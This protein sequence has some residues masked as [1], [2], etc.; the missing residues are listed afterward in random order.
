M[1]KGKLAKWAEN[2]HFDHVFEPSLNEI[3]EGATFMKGE[4]HEKVFQNSN[5]ITVELGCGKGEYTMGLARLYPDR[6][7]LGVDV[8]GHRFWSG[9]RESLDEELSNVAF[10]RT[11]IEFINS[12]F[13][14]DEVDEIWLTFSDP[15]PKDQRGTKRIT[16]PI[17]IDR[18]K[19][20]LPKG[21]LIHIKSDSQWLY[22]NTIAELKSN[23]YEVIHD[24]NDLYGGYIDTIEGDLADILR[25]KTYYE[26]LFTE[27]GAVIKYIQFKV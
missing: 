5:P 24:T 14:K 9:A 20:F 11:K 6:N 4:W 1:G 10:L 12:F 22:D 8:K 17:F 7:F 23:A 2:Q 13:D 21:S 15:Q 16:S 26:E 3:I 25:I 18:Y 27:R 19:K